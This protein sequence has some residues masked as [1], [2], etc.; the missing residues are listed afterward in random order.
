MGG[1]LIFSQFSLMRSA[2]A[3]AAT[4]H[5]I[6]SGDE[7][8]R[9]MHALRLAYYDLNQ[10][11]TFAR[12]HVT[13]PAMHEPERA[14]LLWK[15]TELIDSAPGRLDAIYA[16]YCRLLT[17]IGKTNK[18]SEDGFSKINETEIIAEISRKMHQVG[19]YSNAT[20][21]QLQYRL[22]SGFVHNCVWATRTGAKTHTEFGEDRA[23]RQLIGNADN[24]Y[25]GT[26]TAFEV[27][28]L[29][30]ARLQELAGM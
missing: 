30:K 3:G 4:A 14:E 1:P 22:M 7:S 28:K 9:R 6:V 26:V 29:A 20:E 17:G 13:N 12:L 11:A 15:G 27:A 25:N 8:T 5:W 2:L 23:Q 21:V 18:P 24:I 16:E 10:E 19:I